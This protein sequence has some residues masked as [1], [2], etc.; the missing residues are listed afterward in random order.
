MDK[1]EKKL[2]QIRRWALRAR[3]R[4]TYGRF[5]VE[6]VTPRTSALNV[7]LTEVERELIRRVAA[8]RG[9]TITRTVVEAV[10]YYA[11]AEEGSR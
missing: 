9:M 6:T 7:R 3:N 10:R 1:I 11:T 8:E 5:D 4:D 2:A